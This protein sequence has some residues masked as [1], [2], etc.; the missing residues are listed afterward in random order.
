MTSEPDEMEAEIDGGG[1]RWPTTARRPELVGDDVG[2]Q[3]EGEQIAYE[4]EEW[5]NQSRVLLDQLLEGESIMHVWE[6][7]T[8]VVRAVDEEPG[9]RAGRAG[10][11]EPTSRRS[12]PTR[13]RSS[14]SSRTGPTRSASR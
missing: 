6:G 4:F 9:R 12:I 5:D 14:S 1:G 7:A 13:S 3:P 2:E 11:G 8:L 10:G